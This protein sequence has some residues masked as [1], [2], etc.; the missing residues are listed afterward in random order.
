MGSERN[1]FAIFTDYCCQSIKKDSHSRVRRSNRLSITGMSVV[2][3][4]C[5]IFINKRIQ[6]KKQL[7]T[8]GDKRSQ[9]DK[10]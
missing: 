6:K 9:H 5:L 7:Q 2:F 1:H 8:V 10:K 3:V 4:G